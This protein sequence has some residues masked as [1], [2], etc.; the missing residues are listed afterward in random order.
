[1]ISYQISDVTK[2]LEN[3]L[4]WGKM[5]VKGTNHLLILYES[6]FV[7]RGPLEGSQGP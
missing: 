2:R 5:K 3:I 6:S 1:M 4:T 7:L